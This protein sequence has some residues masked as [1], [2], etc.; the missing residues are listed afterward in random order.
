MDWISWVLFSFK[1]RIGR[2]AWLGFF[3]GL[4]L[5]EAATATKHVLYVEG[6]RKKVIYVR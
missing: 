3:A 2:L 5:A 1:G 4:A 6:H